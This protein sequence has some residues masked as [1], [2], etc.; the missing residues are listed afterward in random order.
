MAPEAATLSEVL[1]TVSACEG[2]YPAV[3]THM[4]GDGG[5]FLGR[6]LAVVDT[7]AILVVDFLAAE[8]LRVELLIGTQWQRA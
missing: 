1:T 6:K 2:V 3:L 5:A 7:A 4:Y 8:P